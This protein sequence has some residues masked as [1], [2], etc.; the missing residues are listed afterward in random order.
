MN[1]PPDATPDSHRLFA[2]ARE[3]ADA[4]PKDLGAEIALAGS[5]SRGWADQYS[6]IELNFWIENLDGWPDQ[7]I[8]WFESIGAISFHLYPERHENGS[9]WLE[10]EYRGTLGEAGWHAVDVCEAHYNRTLAGQLNAMA[11][12][13][14]QEL[15]QHAIPLR[16]GEN[17]RRWKAA[18]PSYPEVLG[19]NLIAAAVSDWGWPRYQMLSAAW[20]ERPEPARVVERTHESVR[21]ILRILFAVNRQWEPDLGKWIH[22]WADA[23]PLKPPNLA[24]RIFAIYAAPL[25]KPAQDDLALLI[26]QTLDLIPD[27][28]DNQKIIRANPSNP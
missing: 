19:R 14:L 21:S 17:L 24:D 13:S 16:D 2:V 4:C 22:R 7:M 6:D 10:F 27:T 9:A 5:V 26:Q 18:L 12:G 3:I 28:A 1:L 8:A 20:L 23:L 11:D 25:S 15:L